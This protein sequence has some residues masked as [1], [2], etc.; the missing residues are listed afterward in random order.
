MTMAT[1]ALSRKEQA[2]LEQGADPLRIEIL[3][4]ARRFKRSWLDMAEALLQVKA[5]GA[6]TDWGYAD[7]Y[8]YCEEELLIKRRTVDKLTVSFSTI[9]QHAPQ[10]L[11]KQADM[12]VP[13]YDAVDYFKKVMDKPDA[14]PPEVVEELKTAVFEQGQPA[15]MLRKHFNPIFFAKSTEDVALDALVKAKNTAEKLEKL[16]ADVDGLSESSVTSVGS[17]LEVLT[18][19][20]EMMIPAAKERA[21]VTRAA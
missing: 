19:E 20:L 8:A 14:P 15:N 3:Q 5:S 2:L 16:L 7:L 12:P 13:N 11:E 21:Q 4:R 10:V 18:A 17:A 1:E 9:K 6:F